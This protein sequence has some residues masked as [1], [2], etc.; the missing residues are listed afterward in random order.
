M[1]LNILP[2]TLQPLGTYQAAIPQM[3]GEIYS[4]H[5]RYSSMM[6]IKRLQSYNINPS[7]RYSSLVLWPRDFATAAQLYTLERG[8]RARQ[9]E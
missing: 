5:M 4:F 3:K 6:Y 7:L 8:G 9:V 1:K 2:V